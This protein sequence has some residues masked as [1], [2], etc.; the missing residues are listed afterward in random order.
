M[1]TVTAFGQAR[2]QWTVLSRW[3][4][5]TGTRLRREVPRNHDPD[6]YLYF[7]MKATF[8][9]PVDGK[10]QESS[11]LS[12]F[13]STDFGWITAR[14]LAYNLGSQYPI[15]Y[16]PARPEVFEFGAGYNHL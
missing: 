4:S 5:A 14:A 11:T 8:R 13:G 3:K 10:E 6:G 16:D 15:R 1:L 9:Y 7:Q 12:Y 2:H